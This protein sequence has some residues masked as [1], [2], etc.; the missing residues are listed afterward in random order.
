MRAKL[1]QLN[2]KVQSGQI[3]IPT[4]AVLANVSAADITAKS[5]GC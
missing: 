4:E 1:D 3:R 5:I 2:I